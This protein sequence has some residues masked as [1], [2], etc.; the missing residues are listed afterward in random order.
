MTE[1]PPPPEPPEPPEPVATPPGPPESS[2]APPEPPEASPAP[3]PAGFGQYPPAPAP[4]PPAADRL[5]AAWHGRRE[6]D[7][8]FD[9]ATALG[10]QILTCGVYGIY[11]LYQLVRRSRDHNLRRIELLD[12]ATAVAWEQARARGLADELQPSFERIAP[13]MAV[14]R[15]KTTEFRDP[16]LWAVLAIFVRLVA[17]IVA[18]VLLDGD[19]IAHDYAEGAI[20][21]ELSAIYTRLGAPVPVPD[22]RRLKQP[23]NYV[24]RIVVVFLTC[25]LYLYFWQYDIMTEGNRHFQHNWAW[26]DA[27][28]QS[29][30]RLVAA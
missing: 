13:H 6:S 20:E 16:T 3:P 10:W 15:A 26:E 19:L 14:L 4:A 12:A 21:T 22:P 11:V 9:F 30:Q 28:A 7:Y 17:D 18:Y 24:A 5:R 25:G 27:L 29:V 23:H 2:P 1:E 8:I